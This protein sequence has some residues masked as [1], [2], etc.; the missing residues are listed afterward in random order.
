MF[1]WLSQEALF[2]GGGI[3]RSISS[4][5]EGHSASAGVETQHKRIDDWSIAGSL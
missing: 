3:P 4:P 5:V 2:G 1:T